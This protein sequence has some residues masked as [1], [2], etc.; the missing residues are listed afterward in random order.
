MCLWTGKRNRE[1]LSFH[2]SKVE[3][4]EVRTMETEL[5]EERLFDFLSWGKE[6]RRCNAMETEYESC[7]SDN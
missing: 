2:V 1:T 3:H 5:N 7:K 6:Y 4:R